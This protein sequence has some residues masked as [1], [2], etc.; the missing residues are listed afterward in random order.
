MDHVG[1]GMKRKGYRWVTAAEQ[2][3]NGRKVDWQWDERNKDNQVQCEK[4]AVIELSKR[5]SKQKRICL[6]EIEILSKWCQIKL[7]IWTHAAVC[8]GVFVTDTSRGE[9]GL[10]TSRNRMP[11]SM[12]YTVLKSELIKVCIIISRSFTNAQNLRKH[13]NIRSKTYDYHPTDHIKTLGNLLDVCA[14]VKDRHSWASFRKYVL[15][16]MAKQP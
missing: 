4:F 11:S 5:R 3:E 12:L 7:K 2:K 9:K 16:Q 15:L 10:K 14:E 8:E 6:T 13:T 1:G